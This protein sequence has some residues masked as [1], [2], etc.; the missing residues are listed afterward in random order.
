MTGYGY[1]YSRSHTSDD[2]WTKALTNYNAADARF[3]PISTALNDAERAYFALKKKDV[4]ALPQSS[5]AE[6]RAKYRL[7]KAYE[8]DRLYGATLDGAVKALLRVPAPNLSALIQKVEIT[9]R[10][11]GNNEF[12]E[13]ILADLKSLL[14]GNLSSSR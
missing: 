10:Y 5:P 12:G 14:E 6:R 2:V 13:S 1:T 7:D 8:D 3:K 4:Q 9:L 11:D